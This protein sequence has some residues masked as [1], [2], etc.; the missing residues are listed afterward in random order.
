MNAFRNTSL[1]ILRKTFRHSVRRQTRRLDPVA[2]AALAD[3]IALEDNDLRTE[4]EQIEAELEQAKRT[5]LE[6]V[7]K[8]T[9]LGQRSRQ[10]RLTLDDRARELSEKQREL[11]RRSDGNDDTDLEDDS[12][13]QRQRQLDDLLEKWE[14]D[15]DALDN[16]LKIQKEILVNCEG[17]RR[18]I[19]ELEQKQKAC[20]LLTNE[21]QEFL[22]EAE[23]SVQD[24]ENI[25]RSENMGEG[26]ATEMANLNTDSNSVDEQDRDYSGQDEVSCTP[27]YSSSQEHGA[28][29]KDRL[30]KT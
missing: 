2:R 25:T 17:M 16:I 27:L 5:L 18:H 9:F 1:A 30:K 10:Y 15:Q 12:L 20:R 13:H 29:R 23:A 19:K 4:M 21:H 14:R 22:D 3:E 24:T 6:F 11:R 26:T 7:R 28:E 8:E